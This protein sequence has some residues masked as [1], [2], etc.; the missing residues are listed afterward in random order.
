VAVKTP[1][2]LQRTRSGSSAV[3]DA[4][5]MI[6]DPHPGE[7][8]IP[9]SLHARDPREARRLGGLAS[10]NADQWFGF[11]RMSDDPHQAERMIRRETRPIFRP[12]GLRQRDFLQCISAAPWPQVTRASP[13]C[14]QKTSLRP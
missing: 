4:C 1:P 2:F 3:G 10:V 9:V 8:G 13:W 6:C 12:T 7:R 14:S 11:Q 5:R